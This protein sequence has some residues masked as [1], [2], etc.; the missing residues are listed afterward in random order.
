M[1]TVALAVR[2]VLGG[3]PWTAILFITVLALGSV[4]AT[5]LRYVTGLKSQLKAAIEDANANAAVIIRERELR[6]YAEQRSD[7]VAKKIAQQKLQSERRLQAVRTAPPSDD[8]PL[9]PVL[10]SAL[11]SLRRSQDARGVDSTHHSAQSADMQ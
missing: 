5:G 10:R 9:A 11:D 8:G 2:Q 4:V 7:D 6:A 1:N 3:L